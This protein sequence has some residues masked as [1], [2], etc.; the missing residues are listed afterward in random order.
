[1]RYAHYPLNQT[2]VWRKRNALKHTE[3]QT[4][5]GWS[6]FRHLSYDERILLLTFIEALGS[7]RAN[8]AG[9]YSQVGKSVTLTARQ[10]EG[11]QPP[12]ITRQ[13]ASW[14]L[15]ALRSKTQENATFLELRWPTPLEPLGEVLENK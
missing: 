13:I 3:T 7:C 8:R 1:M 9:D 5:M 6:I 4:A 11:L 10:C 14:S 15:T 2:T 12:W